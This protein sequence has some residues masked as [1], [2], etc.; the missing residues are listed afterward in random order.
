MGSVTRAEVLSLYRRIFRIARSWQAQSA[1]QHDTDSE[2]RY[3]VQ[4]ARTLFRQ[5][6]QVLSLM[7]LFISLYYR[8]LSTSL[9]FNSSLIS[10]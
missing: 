3:I 2:K 10:S 6:M 7:L 5:N 9:C 4:E 1:L 8:T